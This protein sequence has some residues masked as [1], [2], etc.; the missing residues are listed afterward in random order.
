MNTKLVGVETFQLYA[1][2]AGGG[3]WPLNVLR[4][5]FQ[6][7]NERRTLREDR[8]ADAP[9]IVS[10]GTSPTTYY[11]PVGG[12]D[13][14]TTFSVNRLVAEIEVPSFTADQLPKG[15]FFIITIDGQE[16]G[17]GWLPVAIV[18]IAGT[19]DTTEPTKI[20]YR[21]SVGSTVEN[22]RASVERTG[23]SG[24]NNAELELRVFYSADQVRQVR[25]L[26]GH[27]LCTTVST[28]STAFNNFIAQDFVTNPVI[29][30]GRTT[31]G[32]T[33]G[34]TFAGAW[35]ILRADVTDNQNSSSLVRISM[36][37]VGQWR[38]V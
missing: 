13:N 33:Q 24:T 7:T 3:N 20:S 38:D 21:P 2:P 36:E 9:A 17:G 31:G 15:Q 29:Y 12:L 27:V 11:S 6:A 34:K 5:S 10:I 22:V 4:D 25:Y 19:G 8:T 37:Q 28:V 35:I 16:T 30:L 26:T 1:L 18:T 32:G 23:G 14:L